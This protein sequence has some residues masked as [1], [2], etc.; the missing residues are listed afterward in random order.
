MQISELRADIRMGE[1]REPLLTAEADFDLTSI[2][3]IEDK[4]EPAVPQD[5]IKS[6][7]T[8]ICTRS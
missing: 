2:A 8:E 6:E 5:W 4:A 7:R 3:G 1:E